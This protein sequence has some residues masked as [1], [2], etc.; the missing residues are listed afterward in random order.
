MSSKDIKP[1]VEMAVE[2]IVYQ[3][4]C[5]QPEGYS[6]CPNPDC[7]DQKPPKVPREVCGKP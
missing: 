6:V 3:C 7:K 1:G 2:W 5:C 4:G